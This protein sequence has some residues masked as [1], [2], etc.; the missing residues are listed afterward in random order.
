[1]PPR[2]SRHRFGVN[3]RER[4]VLPIR[5]MERDGAIVFEVIVYGWTG[6]DACCI[7]GGS[8]PFIK[9][10]ERLGLDP[11]RYQASIWDVQL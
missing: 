3:Y 11:N 8:D 6:R 1:M 2:Y 4:T 9:A 5:D 10:V 7:P